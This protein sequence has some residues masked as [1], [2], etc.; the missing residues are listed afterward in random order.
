M[1]NRVRILPTYNT[2]YVT[3]KRDCI[4]EIRKVINSKLPNRIQVI[5]YASYTDEKIRLGSPLVVETVL[6]I[7]LNLYWLKQLDLQ[8]S[9]FIDIP[10]EKM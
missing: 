9:I 3:H 2:K 5:I 4:F 8:H 7:T 1:N 6:E 10:Q